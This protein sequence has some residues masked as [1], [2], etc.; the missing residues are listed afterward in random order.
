MKCTST[1]RRYFKIAPN[2]WDAIII[3]DGSGSVW[4]T[5]DKSRGMGWGS[6]LI[7]A[8]S[9]ESFDF[10][11][12]ATAGTNNI[13]EILALLQPLWYLEHI[14][15]G[16]RE[17]GC[18][19]HVISDSQYVVQAINGDLLKFLH[20][21]EKNRSLWFSVFGATR[22]GL[23]L[24]GHHVGREDLAIQ[25]LI[26]DISHQTRVSRW[27]PASSPELQAKLREWDGQ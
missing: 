18:Q 4:D 27:T 26:H 1:L 7:L 15:A 11:G 2:N 9:A 12:S 22:S 17:G 21:V 5:T 3:C 14:E 19:V 20:K 8:N 16:L 25:K 10:G 23:V 6:K 24:T 13:A